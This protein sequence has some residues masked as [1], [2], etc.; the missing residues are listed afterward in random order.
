MVLAG[1]L[2]G[3]TPAEARNGIHYLKVDDVTAPESAEKLVFRISFYT[4]PPFPAR[5]GDVTVKYTTVGGS[6]E[7]GIDYTKTAGTA[8]IAQNQNHVD[9]TVPVH[10]DGFAEPTEYFGF[11]L[12]NP[13][14]A[15]IQDGEAIGNIGND[16]GPPPTLSVNDVTDLEGDS[17][18]KPFVFTVTLGGPAAQQPVKVNVA[19]KDGDGGAKAGSDYVAKQT[20]MTF[21]PGEP[22]TQEFSVLVNGDLTIEQDEIFTVEL[23]VGRNAAITKATGVGTIQSD[24]LPKDQI[25]TGPGD[26]AGPHIRIFDPNGVASGG[27]FMAAD[28][29]TSTFGFRV[30]RGDFS[31]NDGVQEVV[32]APMK[33]TPGAAYRPRPLVRVFNQQGQFLTA[34]MAYHPD[35]FGGVSVAVGDVDPRSPGDEIVTAPGP[36]PTAGPHIRVWRVQDDPNNPPGDDNP[37]AVFEITDASFFAYA[38]EFHGGVNLAT[39]DIVREVGGQNDPQRDEIVTVP[40]SDGGPHVSVFGVAVANNQPKPYSFGWWAYD[41]AFRGGLTVASGNFDAD[42]AFEVVTGAGPGGGPHV[43]AWNAVPPTNNA[44]GTGREHTNGG[45]MAFDPRFTG[46]VHVSAGN[47]KGTSSST[48]EIIV[49][50]G[51]GGGPHVNQFDGNGNFIFGFMAYDPNMRSGVTVAYGGGE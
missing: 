31:G 32:V 30:A 41:P 45:F 24:D 37:L 19:T 27:G 10:N 28:P 7:E 14:N 46:G 47:T 39:G 20:T 36:W 34:F 25:T 13:S 50:A 35:L 15:S 44:P 4:D 8:T 6:A 38:P 33:A 16:D 48:H 21:N 9:I 18:T 26:N 5:E 49:G 29:A 3:V 42:P 51:S 12:S 22:T 43:R 11:V 40:M 17:G 2:S 1:V 23:T